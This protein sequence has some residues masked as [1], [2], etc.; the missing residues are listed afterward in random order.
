MKK[1]D[2]IYI[3]IMIMPIVD[4][5]SSVVT[6]NFENALTLGMILKTI[7]ILLSVIYVFFFSHSKYK[8]I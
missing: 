8:K 3:L 5:I 4:L 7:L 1:K 6:R 2:W